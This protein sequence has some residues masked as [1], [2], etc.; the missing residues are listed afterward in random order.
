LKTRKSLPGAD[1]NLLC[2]RHCIKTKRSGTE[3]M[4]DSE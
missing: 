3:R 2:C 4:R 1:R